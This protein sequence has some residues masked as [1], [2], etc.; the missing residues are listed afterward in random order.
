[1]TAAGR[2][3]AIHSWSGTGKKR[4][5]STVLVRVKECATSYRRQGEDAPA[6]LWVPPRRRRTRT[7]QR[8]GGGPLTQGELQIEK[9]EKEYFIELLMSSST[10]GGGEVATERPHAASSTT[11]QPAKKEVAPQ[12]EARNPE[13]ARESKPVT[14]KGKRRS[15][16]GAPRGESEPDTKTG[17]K[18]AGTQSGKESEKWR[19]SGRG[20]GIPPDPPG[21]PGTE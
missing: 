18:E 13:K 14:S 7:S 6:E 3:R 20:Q 5:E 17:E 19:P 8:T 9:G 10:L 2:K 15:S 12:P 16:G 21:D 11:G 1:M 4:A